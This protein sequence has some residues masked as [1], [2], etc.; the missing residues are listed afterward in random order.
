M[1]KY[2]KIRVHDG[3][4]WKV[5]T[6]AYV[7][8]GS[9]WVDLGDRNSGSATYRNRHIHTHNGSG[10]VRVTNPQYRVRFYSAGHLLKTEYVAHG[11]NASPPTT[12]AKPAA[13]GRWKY[14]GYNTS[15]TNV[16][17]DIDTSIKWTPVSKVVK[18]DKEVPFVGAPYGTNMRFYWYLNYRGDTLVSIDWWI[19]VKPNGGTIYASSNTRWYIKISGFEQNRACVIDTRNGANYVG[20]GTVTLNATTWNTWV[21]GWITSSYAGNASAKDNRI[22]YAADMA[23]D[24]SK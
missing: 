13:T 11:G 19:Q 17:K 14:D 2:D 8:D 18:Y 23:T 21:S 24:F 9:G 6:R 7:H 5:P 22:P 12:P 4:G 1:A 3:S 10:W 20:Q 15:Y 16:T